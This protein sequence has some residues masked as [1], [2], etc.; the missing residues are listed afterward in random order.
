MNLAELEE[1]LSIFCKHHFNDD[2]LELKNV[3]NMPGHAGFS[4]GFDVDSSNQESRW[5]IRLPPPNVNWRGTADVLRQVE[6]LNALDETNVPHCSVTWSGAELEW[7]GC[8]YFIVPFMEGDVLH[9]GPDG[10]AAS[11]SEEQLYALGKQVMRA[12]VEV[13]HVDIAKVPYLGDPVPFDEDVLR[14]DRFYE[15]A[16]DPHLLSRV[17]ECRQKLLDHLPTS[18]RVG[19]FHG[20]FQTS[21][22]FCSKDGRLRAIIDWELT[23]V[24]ATLNDVGWI[25]TFADPHA[26]AMDRSERPMFLDPETLSKYYEEYF[27]QSLPDISWF[28]A[29]AAYKFAIITGFNLSLHRRG[30]RPDPTWEQTALSMTPLIDRALELLG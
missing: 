9:V 30:K 20:D 3:R 8:P 11:L 24:G 25:C 1:R 17:P 14:W 21:N 4:Y 2:E 16:A 29:L 7:F 18:T 13:H 10:W 22:L 19:I 26:W 15:R 27:G 6:V 12:L 28:R 23:G 5:Y